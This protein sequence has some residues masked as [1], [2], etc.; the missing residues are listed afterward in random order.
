M[1]LSIVPSSTLFS[2]AS[3]RPIPVKSS[4]TSDVMVSRTP[5]KTINNMAAIVD[6]ISKEEALTDIFN[7]FD[8]DFTGE[9][10]AEQLQELHAGLRDGGISLLQVE[11][12]IE[13]V[14]AAETC[15]RQE[16]Y[17]VLNEMDRRYYLV[18]DLQW[19]FA[20]LDREKKG[21][22]SERE[23]RFLFQAVHDDFFSHR[24]WLKFLRSRAAAGSGISFAEIEVP[25][26]DIP[27]MDWLEE[28]KV[29]EDKAKEEVL[30]RNKEK[31][32]AEEEARKAAENKA[33]LEKEAARRREDASR[34]KAEAE[35]AKLKAEQEEAERKAREKE[36]ER[37]RA[38]YEEDMKK[39]RE[40]EA[41]LREEEER[42]RL[43]EAKRLEEEDR[44]R[45]E[46]EE[47]DQKWKKEEL[48]KQQELEREREERGKQ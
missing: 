18:K 30:R 29:D 27:T 20:M 28:E 22:I 21:T 14:C 16:L 43:E 36:E 5:I 41:K 9:L 13:A 17:D 24:R 7:R 47:A 38:K 40:E 25:L 42:L 15:D 19:E 12:S 23:A 10:R 2:P 46:Q 26:C 35:A 37:N 48:L 1:E 11:A 33:R 45:R 31:E 6:W 4:R 3:S 39:L 8:T 44:K 34:K 32:R